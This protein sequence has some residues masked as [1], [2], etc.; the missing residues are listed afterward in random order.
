MAPG[1]PLPTTP[2]NRARATTAL[3]LLLSAAVAGGA[4]GGGVQAAQAPVAGF[5]VVPPRFEQDLKGRSFSLEV[6]FR[7]NTSS[8][9][10]PTFEIT[11]LGHDLDGLPLFPPA[12]PAFGSLRL[13]SP[14]ARLAPGE[15]RRVTLTGSVPPGGP[16]LY[17][18]VVASFPPSGGVGTGVNIT[19]RLASLVL[20][21]SPKPWIESVEVET[22]SARPAGDDESVEFFA[23]L[24]NTGNVH[25]RPTGNVDII[26]RGKVFDT[27]DLKPEVVIPAYA[28]RLGGPW[29]V[30][31]GFDGT[32]QLEAK[33]DGPGSPSTGKGTATFKSGKLVVPPGGLG[34]RAGTGSGAD[35]D[36]K[37]ASPLDNDVKK[38]DSGRVLLSI[39]GA[40]LL[41]AV[42]IILFLLAKRRRS[43]DEEE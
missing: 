26:F 43:A 7:N 37:G 25:V 9:A 39:F 8:I 12:T 16:G 18:A 22:V 34:P 29:R 13:S 33:I 4:A 28:R 11:A 10:S 2:R 1:F 35:S 21:R 32:V 24:R 38:S 27:I 30:P 19:Q 15:A 5:Q 41:L 23:Q 40:L 42:L 3:A 36:D 20:L 6:S 14:S 31:A 17:A